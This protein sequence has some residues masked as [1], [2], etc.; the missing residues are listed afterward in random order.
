MDSRARHETTLE[1][2]QEKG[3]LSVVELSERTGTS[4]M[5]VR[6]DLQV[7]EQEGVL[8]RVHAS[9]ISVA[10]K[11]DLRPYPVQEKRDIVAKL[12]VGEAAAS[13]TWSLVWEV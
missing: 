8:R 7:L 9:A 13:P 1:L 4:P 2:L 11:G 5:T 12:Q 6:R 3:E 10:S